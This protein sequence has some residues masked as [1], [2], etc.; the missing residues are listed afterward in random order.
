MQVSSAITVGKL[1]SVDL[2]VWDSFPLTLG[3]TPKQTYIDGIP[4]IESPHVVHKG[5]STQQVT[6]AGDYDE[7]ALEA[8][9]TRGEPDL[10]PK[11]SVKNIMFT[12]VKHVYTHNHESSLDGTSEG[13]VLVEDGEIVCVG[14]CAASA[15]VDVETIDLKG[16]SIA[17]GLITVGSYLGLMEIRQEKS[18]SDGVSFCPYRV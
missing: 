15:G 11:R 13:A 5:A 16:G 4:Q 18:T 6:A 8:F 3:A 12:G 2:V 17:P 1:N 14:D 7:E 10:A 9:N